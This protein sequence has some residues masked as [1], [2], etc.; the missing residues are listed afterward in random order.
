VVGHVHGKKLLSD[1]HPSPDYTFGQIGF[2]NGMRAI[3]EFGKL[4][5]SH[6]T[7]DRFWADNRLTVYGTKGYTWGETDGRWGA[8]VDGQVKEEQGQPF[9]VQS[10]NTIQ[11]LYLAELAHWLDGKLP[12][13]SC[14]IEHAYDGYEV[15]EALCISAMDHVRVDLPL[16][17]GRC[18]D[19]FERMRKELPECTERV[20]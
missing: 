9:A 2:E 14:A 18:N 19:M 15:M 7:P 12:D 4:S 10:A 16:K 17:A 13:H 11:V 8:L 5:A 20:K 6:M 3:V 1:H